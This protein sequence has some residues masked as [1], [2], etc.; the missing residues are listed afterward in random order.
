LGCVG[1]PDGIEQVCGFAGAGGSFTGG[2]GGVG[3]FG[4]T[5]GVIGSGGSA[6]AD[7]CAAEA[8]SVCEKCACTSCFGDITACFADS[9]CP[10]ILSCANQTGCSGIDCLQ[11]S[12][13]ETIIDQFGGI[14]GSSVG[15]ALPLFSCLQQAACPCGFA[16]S[17]SQ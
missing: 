5:G 10:A 11:P 15:L 16:G 13:C 9:G 7:M 14:S 12:T 8:N 2:S 1:A 3:A 17:S 6:G 4:G